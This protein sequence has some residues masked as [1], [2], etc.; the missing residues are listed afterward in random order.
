MSYKSTHTGQQIDAGVAAALNP[1]TTPTSGSNALMTSGGTKSA[2]DTFVRPNLLD[3]PNFVGGGSQQGGEQFPINQRGQTSYQNGGYT[4]D[5]WKCDGA[6]MAINSDGLLVTSS[7]WYGRIFQRLPTSVN[8]G[9]LANTVTLSVLVKN[10][11]G[12]VVRIALYNTA[13]GQTLDG[14]TS[15]FI[16]I[17]ENLQLVTVTGVANGFQ[18]SDLLE[19][20]IYSDTNVQNSTTFI[21]AK[22]ELGPDQTLAHQENGVWVLNEIPNYQ[23][24]LA[25]C[26]MYQWVPSLDNNN[27]STSVVTGTADST[28]SI[29]LVVYF[30]VTMRQAP[31]FGNIIIRDSG[32]GIEYTLAENSYAAVE[33]KDGIRYLYNISGVTLTVGRLYNIYFIADANL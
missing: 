30:P 22:L 32:T 4:I 19:C 5:R 26:Q 31:R 33:S 2:L 15:P 1:D 11:I 14:V 12:S 23:Q 18:L 9:I 8:H 25:K 28:S 20:L 10:S 17:S 13:N 6:S 24:E 29:S 21:A 16:R 27:V 3:N 7:V